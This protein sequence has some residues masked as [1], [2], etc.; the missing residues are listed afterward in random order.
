MG[1]QYRREPLTNRH[2]QQFLPLLANY[3]DWPTTTT[4]QLRRS[5]DHPGRHRLAPGPK[6]TP[7]NVKICKRGQWNVRMIVETTFSMMT[8]VWNSK[9]MRHITWRGFEAHL[10]Y[11]MIAFNILVNW[12]G[13]EPDAKGHIHRSIAHFTL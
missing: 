9:R 2:D 7:D 12:N 4:G 1:L 6:E 5:D 11:L 13:L 3:D 8:N 10:S